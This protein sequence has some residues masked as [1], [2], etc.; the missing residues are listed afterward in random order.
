MTPFP[1]PDPAA[2][3]FQYLEDL[4]C[5]HWLSQVLFTALELDL[6]GLLDRDGAS[7]PDLA[8]ALGAGE[9]ELIRLLRA[10]ARL[11]LV[12]T[13]GDRWY[14]SQAAGRFLVRGKPDFMGDFFLYRLYMRPQW[15]GLTR[16][17]S[18]RHTADPGPGDYGE[19]NRNYVRSTDA[20]IRQKAGTIADRICP[21]MA[22][23]TLLDLGGGAG[24]LIR[25]LR[26][27]IPG[28][29]AW[30]FDLEEVIS[31]GRDLFPDDGDWAGITPVGGDFR[32]HEFGRK[33]DTVLMSNFVHAY[34][35]DEAREL[36]AKALALTAEDGLVVIHDYFPDRA[37][38]APQ[39]GPLYDLAMMLN[40]Y[41][42]V[43]HD[44][45]SLVRQLRAGGFSH[46]AVVDLDTDTGL[47]LARRH[48]PLT[49]PAAPLTGLARELGLRP[50]APIHP[51]DVVT[52]PWVRE[53]CRFGC[54]GFGRT[55]QCP[56]HTDDADQ[57][58]HLL[59]SYTRAFLI[60]G[61]PPGKVFHGHLLALERQAFLDGY[62]KALV[63][64]AGP[65]QVCDSCKSADTETDCRFP[66]KARP[67][68]EASGIDVYATAR[69]AGIPLSPV[70]KK[71]DY[72][73]YIGLLLLE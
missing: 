25:V 47:I 33:F 35:P 8:L 39:K 58:R 41:N 66:D 28:T 40:T 45:E 29:R 4:A 67:S 53:K 70:R 52:A 46:T 9:A 63:L 18:P 23:G 5:A 38:A 37:G 20:L 30:L 50:P 15:D 27:R 44:S 68:M 21:E 26:E 65:C 36:L 11:E 72:V 71:G 61:T 24:S 55:L 43:C 16:K 10:M 34:G 42:G 62:H 64:G 32:S 69:N 7:A 12:E 19:R 57:T 51:R 48:R 13:H 3:G 31:A 60:R 2:K 54:P 49:L 17:I 59:D 22:A 73:T 14:N 6:F 56:P 1:A